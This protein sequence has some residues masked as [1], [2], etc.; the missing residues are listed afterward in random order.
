MDINANLRD[1]QKICHVFFNFTITI[2]RFQN[3]LKI[4]MINQTSLLTITPIRCFLKEQPINCNETE[5]IVSLAKWAEVEK[6][7]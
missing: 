6:F 5:C 2:H 7:N 3:L 1:C 4:L